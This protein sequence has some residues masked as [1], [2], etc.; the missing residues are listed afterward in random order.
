VEIYR[1]AQRH[2]ARR[3]TVLK[4]L[5]RQIGRCTLDPDPDGFQSLVRAIVSQQISTKAA[6]AIHGRLKEALGRSGITPA[7]ILRASDERLRNAGL[8]ANKGRSLRDLADKVKSKAVPLHDCHGLSDEEVIERLITVRGIG[9]WTA[10]MFLI[11]SLGRLD[12][13]PVDDFGLRAAAQRNY[14]LRDLPKKA[15]LTELAEPWRPYRSI[16]TWYMWRSAGFVPRSGDE[17]EV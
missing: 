2:L 1:K 10:E 3:D 14:Q 16:G 5:I 4:D 15:A 13:L 9:R 8:S 12:V 6:R 11:F 7:A 17:E